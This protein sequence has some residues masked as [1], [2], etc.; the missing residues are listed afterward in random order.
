MSWAGGLSGFSGDCLPQPPLT[1]I[2]ASSEQA[3]ASRRVMRDYVHP[4]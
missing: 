4:R 2:V 1:Q 3:T